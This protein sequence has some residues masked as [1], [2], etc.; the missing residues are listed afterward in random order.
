LLASLAIL[1][2]VTAIHRAPPA[3]RLAL[4]VVIFG[5]TLADAQEAAKAVP[6]SLQVR[7]EKVVV[8]IGSRVRLKAKVKDAAGKDMSTPVVFYSLA[9]VRFDS[10]G[11]LV[12]KTIEVDALRFEVT[13]RLSLAQ[14][15]TP[16]SI[17]VTAPTIPV[18]APTWV[19]RPT[20]DSMVYIA[21]SKSGSILEVDLD[22]WQVRRVFAEAGQGPYNLAVVESRQLLIVTLKEAT[23]DGK[24]TFVTNEGVAGEPGTVEVYDDQSLRRLASVDVGKQA[25]GLAFWSGP[26]AGVD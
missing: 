6:A 4:C 8:E 26:S 3:I 9:L 16:E 24:F 20:S 25:G 1:R 17:P 19:T 23:A 5:A 7:P 18:I 21:G 14:G 11:L 13:R 12:T 10:A 15:K 22:E 2:A